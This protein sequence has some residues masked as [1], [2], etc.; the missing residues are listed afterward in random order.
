MHRNPLTATGV[1]L[2]DGRL[3]ALV[4]REQNA[5]LPNVLIYQYIVK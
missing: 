4:Y 5:R 1:Y 2:C 3:L